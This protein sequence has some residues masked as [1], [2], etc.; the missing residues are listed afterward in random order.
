MSREKE[1]GDGKVVLVLGG[2]PAGVLTAARLADLGH[3]VTL[4]NKV[5]AGE[6]LELTPTE[7]RELL[8]SHGLEASADSFGPVVETEV[9][10]QG[11][12]TG[13]QQHVVHRRLLDQAL[14]YD[15]ARRH[16]NIVGGIAGGIT[17]VGENWRVGVGEFEY[18][19]DFLIE[20]RGREA[21]NAGGQ[22]SV[23]CL[24]MRY[25]MPTDYRP[26]AAVTSFREGWARFILGERREASLQ[27]YLSGEN[28]DIPVRPFPLKK[29]FQSI[30]DEL[31]GTWAFL[32]DAQARGEVE[33]RSAFS[34]LREPLIGMESIR[35]GDAAMALEPLP[36]FGMEQG[37]ENALLALPVIE[38]W[39]QGGNKQQLAAQYKDQ[40]AAA[41]E[42]LIRSK[43]TLFPSSENK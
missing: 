5:R 39:L 26:F 24:S 18:E 28:T 30:V 11:K 33:Q 32:A 23:S 6:G 13:G 19:A 42:A 21:G 34:R 38:S 15:V 36:G 35:I 29:K 22:D 14:L 1:N 16:V 2:G 9:V 37:L 25:R 10:W 4:V 8:R 17:R 7:V 12:K 31:S 43:N 40:V 20:A 27:V 41:F 3:H